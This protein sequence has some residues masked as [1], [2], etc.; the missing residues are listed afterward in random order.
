M[1]RIW[2]IFL[3]VSCLLTGCSSSFDASDKVVAPDNNTIPLY[4]SWRISECLTN[5]PTGNLFIGKTAVFTSDTI[6]L[7]ES[8][9][10]SVNYKTKRVNAGEYLL[11]KY[12]GTAD[13]LGIKD[14]E[15]FV[16]TVSSEGNFLYDFIKIDNDNLIA[17][18]EDEL[19]HLKRISEQIEN[20]TDIH[21]NSIQEQE[22]KADIYNRQV[23]RSGLLIGIRT[24]VESEYNQ[25]SKY[26]YRTLWVAAENKKPKPV[27]ETDNI[28]LPR[29]S[30]FWR[31]EV[32]QATGNGIVQDIPV[33]YSISESDSVILN[34]AVEDVGFWEN[35]EGI[36]RKKILYA[37][38]DFVCVESL[39][40]GKYRDSKETW[41]EN[42]LQTL[43][44]DSIL[45]SQGVRISDIAGENGL[46]ALKNGLSELL[47]SSNTN[48]SR[49]AVVRDQESSFSLY[50]KTGHW[51]FKGR[52]NLGK[53][54]AVPFID[55]NINLIP[56]SELVAYDVFHLSWTYIK[57][58]I[59]EA[60]DAYTS[61]NGDIAVVLT[62][63][64]LFIY[65]MDN[66]KLSGSPLGEIS[67]Q[68]GDSV[69]MA[70]WATGDYVEKWENTFRKSNEVRELTS[71]TLH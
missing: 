60:V 63:N 39:G 19:F 31:L 1:K 45:T 38:N 71:D 56:P 20:T 2:V 62:Q 3:F 33:A 69:V 27:L 8:T 35:R 4:G 40:E 7:G 52:L 29:K 43:P 67:L 68:D 37:G 59:P 42:R 55:F 9:W 24:P 25:M 26:S 65:A 70:E 48:I 58:R 32:K 17:N 61:P 64:R 47:S 34:T 23:F 53:N 11:Y 28:F 49:K 22:V 18:I 50:R 13:K 21:L 66:D 51:Y 5:S 57:D 30:G 6:S 14:N 10:K 54:S 36:L 15:V 46:L 12:E 44:V 16:I 41:Q